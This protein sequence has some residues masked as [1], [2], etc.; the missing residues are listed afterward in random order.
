MYILEYHLI[1]N[2]YQLVSWDR[3]MHA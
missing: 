3:C 1:V 2:Y